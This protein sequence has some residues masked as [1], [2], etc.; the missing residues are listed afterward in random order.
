[1]SRTSPASFLKHASEVAS[2]YGFKP[3]R[4]IEREH[5]QLTD[6]KPMRRGNPVYSFESAAVLCA[7]QA[8][9]RPQEPVLGFYATPQPAF[10]PGTL[11]SREVGEFGLQVVGTGESVGEIVLLKTI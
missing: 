11:S 9:L 3:M 1:M 7:A 5:A 6:A 10:M 8:A 4:E 2:F